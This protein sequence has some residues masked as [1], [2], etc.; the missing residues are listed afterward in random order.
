MPR[1]LEPSS[2][3]LRCSKC[4]LFTRNP[5]FTLDLPTLGERL[6]ARSELTELGYNVRTMDRPQRWRVLLH[7]VDEFGL[8][9]VVW[10]LEG[11]IALRLKQKDGATKYAYAISEWRHDLDRLRT[12]LKR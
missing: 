8:N 11:N 12:E 6:A 10:R 3:D 2:A 7:A 5:D 4:A 1:A 9:H